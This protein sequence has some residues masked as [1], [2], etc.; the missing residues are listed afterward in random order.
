MEILI[1][2][3]FGSLY[4]LIGAV[5]FFIFHRYIRDGSDEGGDNVASLMLL[6][7]WPVALIFIVI[8]GVSLEIISLGERIY[9]GRNK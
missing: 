3:G 9:R 2:A 6:L 4:F 7:L 1:T 8:V 5:L